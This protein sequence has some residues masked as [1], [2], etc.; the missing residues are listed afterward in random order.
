MTIHGSKGLEAPVVFLADCNS[1][2]SNK[3]AYSSLV[4][5]PA[6][7]SQPVNF[8][9]QLSKD[10]T[11]AITQQLQQEKLKAQQLEELNLL[12]VALTRAREQ[13]YISGVASRSQANSW[14]Q[15]IANGLEGVTE[16]ENSLNGTQISVYRY[17]NYPQAAID[18]SENSD[19]KK[20]KEHDDK[21]NKQLDARLLKPIGKITPSNFLIAPSLAVDKNFKHDSDKQQQQDNNYQQDLAQW[22]GIN[23][24][25][26]IEQLCNSKNYPAAEADILKIHHQ[27]T[28]EAALKNPAYITHIDECI[29]EAVTS[30][31][32]ASFEALFNTDENYQTYNEMPLMY[33]QKKQT[34]YGI[35]DRVI[36]DKQTITVI[37]Y[38][39]HQ[40]KPG[41]ST[42]DSA[43]QFQSQLEYYRSGI[44][45]LW[46]QHEIKTGILF[47][48]HNEIIWLDQKNR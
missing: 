35:V 42:K 28:A 16:K 33:K 46:P 25:R 41:E 4:Q 23:I 15:I 40:L 38:K 14:Y 7:K 32:H 39:S 48:H 8:Q 31:N 5:W 22:R 24:H 6:D 44:K 47:T 30:Y 9:L 12:Y 43:L 45:K 10:Y 3:N 26:A 21:T 34:V 2:T 18:D 11:D 17:S 13:L 19:H 29:K 1:T 36:K 37:D 20:D 27:L